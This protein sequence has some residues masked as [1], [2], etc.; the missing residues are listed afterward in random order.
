MPEFMDVHRR[1][2]S[3]RYDRWMLEWVIVLVVI[4]AIPVLFGWL[5]MHLAATKGRVTGGEKLGWFL[6]GFLF[7]VLGL[8][9]ALVVPPKAEAVHPPD[10]D[11]RPSLITGPRSC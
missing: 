9:V 4:L 10:S 5:S 1:S 3:E 2:R 7:P 8:I 6:L 11:G